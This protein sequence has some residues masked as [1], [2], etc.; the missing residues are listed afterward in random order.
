MHPPLKGLARHYAC[1]RPRLSPPL[2]QRVGGGFKELPPTLFD[3]V[4]SLQQIGERMR[5][6]KEK[7]EAEALAL[8]SE[9]G[10]LEGQLSDA[11]A[12]A[13]RAERAQGDQEAS[14]RGELSRMCEQLKRAQSQLDEEHAVASSEQGKADGEIERL[15]AQLREVSCE[16]EARKR[17][18]GELLSHMADGE[19]KQQTKLLQAAGEL[20]EVRAAAVEDRARLSAAQDKLAERDRQIELV[21]VG[22]DFMLGCTHLHSTRLHI[23]PSCLPNIAPS[24]SASPL[25]VFPHQRAEA[26]LVACCSVALSASSTSS[27]RAAAQA[28]QHFSQAERELR[29][30]LHDKEGRNE[31]ER[32]QLE[33]Q[34]KQLEAR[35]TSTATVTRCF[36]ALEEAWKAK[37]AVRQEASSNVEALKWQLSSARK[38]AEGLKHQLA[39]K[40]RKSEEQR[41]ENDRLLCSVAALTEQAAHS[42]RGGIGC[43]DEARRET[44]AARKETDSSKAVLKEQLRSCKREV[45][46]DKLLMAKV[47]GPNALKHLQN[48]LY[49][50]HFRLS[51]AGASTGT[52][53]TCLNGEALEESRRENERLRETNATLH[54][55]LTAEIR[56][57]QR[58]RTRCE[59]AERRELIEKALRVRNLALADECAAAR[60]EGAKSLEHERQERRRAE[61]E[62]RSH[63]EALSGRL[64]VEKSRRKEAAREALLAEEASRAVLLAEQRRRLQQ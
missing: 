7:A 62:A 30:A 3:E 8:R 58:A 53:P 2:M 15:S 21:K 47:S 9:L 36:G 54:E 34:I 61:G 38:E 44:E 56:S 14:W 18:I 63:I 32:G 26:H 59:E 60:E 22:A 64:Q 42:C 5:E 13:H 19:Q 12:R 46:G 43:L 48:A 23:C 39:Q 37:E 57:T 31:R 49:R 24:N 55:K 40:T 27:W 28:K 1:E 45:E 16:A 51:R 50:G 20:A 6:D 4:Q 11:L 29:H 25:F 41:R 33:A 17:Q 35:A 10:R 52:V